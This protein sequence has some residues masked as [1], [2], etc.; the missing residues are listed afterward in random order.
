MRNWQLKEHLFG[1]RFI[2]GI[3]LF[4]LGLAF[5]LTL[6]NW[7]PIILILVGILIILKGVFGHREVKSGEAPKS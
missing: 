3:I 7:W 6:K 1:G 5:V 2:A 4:V